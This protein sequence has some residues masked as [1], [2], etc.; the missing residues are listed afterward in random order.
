MKKTLFEISNRVF[1]EISKS[2]INEINF[3]SSDKIEFPIIEKTPKCRVTVPKPRKINGGYLFE[4]FV[5]ENYDESYETIW[6][7]Y[8]ATV[9]HMAVHAKISDYT[10]YEDWMNNKTS[11]KCQKVIDF[12]E[13]LR[14]EEY[15]KRSFP[16][17]LQNISAIKIEFDIKQNKINSM[18]GKKFYN[19]YSVEKLNKI[20]ELRKKLSDEEDLKIDDIVIYLNFLYE[21]QDLLPED[22]L[23]YCMHRS[24][25]FTKNGQIKNIKIKPSG[26]FAR[27]VAD[28]N[29]VWAKQNRNQKS[30]NE[31]E[32]LAEDSHFD[33]VVVGSENL[34]EFVRLS[35]ESEGILRKIRTTARIITN[36]IDTPFTEDAGLL[37]MQFA[38][39]REA[40]K[41]QRI[42]FFEQDLPRKETE[43]WLV[44]IDAS[45]SMISRFEQ[46]KKVALCFSEAAEEINHGD[47]KWGLY[48]FNNNFLVVKDQ[49]E[50]Y[51]EQTKARIGGIEN[52]GF[53]L[54]PDAIDM[55]I[56]ILNKDK[57]SSRKHLILISDGRPFGYHN[58]DECFK[59]SL[60]NA[61]RNRINVIGVGVPKRLSKYF[62]VILD[63][64]SPEESVEKFLRS[65]TSILES[66]R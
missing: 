58:I 11:E 7:L 43:N 16:N 10:K 52:K 1:Y 24:D 64:K 41:N 47:G 51:D 59:R 36:I 37:N 53:S 9:S 29:D 13:D 39:Q 14:V 31:Y 62:S 28:L 21:N 33:E 42:Q 32:E 38:I 65:Y 25:D 48:G 30:L 8:L 34:G 15:L 17:I 40:S 57:E 54:I 66:M 3:R 56:K 27:T 44:I 4:G 46:M 45:A 35:D 5:F 23:P 55:G 61:K 22:D 60:L 2:T 26:E 49:V 20:Q 19:S 50:K 6:G 12:V 18:F 63:D